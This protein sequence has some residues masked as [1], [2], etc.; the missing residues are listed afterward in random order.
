MKSVAQVKEEGSNM[1]AE[2]MAQ[3]PR[4]QR[5]V[6]QLDCFKQYTR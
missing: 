5:F 2:L 6:K 4:I 1:T 3:K